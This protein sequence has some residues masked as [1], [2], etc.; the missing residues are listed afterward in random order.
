MLDKY[1]ADYFPVKSI[2]HKM[3]PSI[4]LVNLLILIF[5][6][7]L[8]SDQYI[9]LVSGGLIIFILIF[10]NVPMKLY[11]KPMFLFI[12]IFLLTAI[13][14]VLC[15]LDIQIVGIILLKIFIIIFN[16]LLIIQTTTASGL[17]TGI[18]KIV[19][20]FNIFFINMNKLGIRATQVF[21]VFPV[22]YTTLHEILN[23]QASRGIDYKYVTFIGRWYA[24]LSVLK[25]VFIVTKE[26]LHI[27]GINMEQRLF[28]LNINRPKVEL[29]NFNA[30]DFLFLGIHLIYVV[31][32]V[33]RL[34]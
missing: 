25:R 15:G 14:M 31:Y 22:F 26:K 11:F 33:A 27:L 16:L 7:C 9:L 30:V 8:T 23:S 10:S 19:N 4:K 6:F 28:N 3:S 17:A 32:F 24:I 18:M 13:V 1:V 21:K 5:V 2:I 20:T 34:K 29:L 12:Y